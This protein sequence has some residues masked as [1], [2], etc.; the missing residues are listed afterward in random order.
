MA[1]KSDS[2]AKT[3]KEPG[4]A[5]GV[6]VKEIQID[7][8]SITTSQELHELLKNELSFPEYYGKNWAAFWDTITS[9]VLLPEVII[10]KNWG[11]ME[12]LLPEDCSE[13]LYL[14]KDIGIKF[15][16]W[17]GVVKFI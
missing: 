10:F 7:V 14:L 12:K 13:L 17:A 4:V 1:K 5:N 11:K 6:R 3:S 15:P 8:G 2:K 9:L 16:G